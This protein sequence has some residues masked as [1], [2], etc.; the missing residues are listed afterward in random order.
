M[1]T[2]ALFAVNADENAEARVTNDENW[3]LIIPSSFGFRH[4]SL[5]D[6]DLA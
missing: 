6:I 1:Q 5:H 2:K 3:R 4:S